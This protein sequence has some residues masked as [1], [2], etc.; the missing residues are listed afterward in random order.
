MEGFRSLMKS[1]LLKYSKHFAEAISAS[2]WLEKRWGMRDE[3]QTHLEA[4]D[5]TVSIED[6]KITDGVLEIQ[7]RLVKELSCLHELYKFFYSIYRDLVV[8]EQLIRF[9]RTDTTIYVDV[10]GGET[11][12]KHY[13]WFLRLSFG[14][15]LVEQLIARAQRLVR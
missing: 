13:G 6:I 3:I 12:D 2:D 14:G 11:V 10:I 5:D 1:E 7:L 4:A 15:R 9:H 8:P